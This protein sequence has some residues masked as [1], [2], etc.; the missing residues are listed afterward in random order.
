MFTARMLASSK[1]VDNTS[2]PFNFRTIAIDLHL[3]QDFAQRRGCW[4]K[5][6]IDPPNIRAAL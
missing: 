1:S 6:T 3:A 5:T 4:G 2:G